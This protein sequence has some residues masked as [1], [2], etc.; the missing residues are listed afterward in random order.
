MF[1]RRRSAAASIAAGCVQARQAVK[2]GCRAVAAPAAV[3]SGNAIWDSGIQG[4]RLHCMV[5]KREAGFI[6]TPAPLLA[7]VLQDGGERMS[8]EM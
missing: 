3:T 2:A 1:A 7:L 4:H 8:C 5:Q 6:A